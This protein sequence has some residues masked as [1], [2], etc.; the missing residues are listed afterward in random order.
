MP[1]VSQLLPADGETR[2]DGSP[3]PP[4]PVAPRRPAPARLPGR[5]TAA[6]AITRKVLEFP[7]NSSTLRMISKV[8]TGEPAAPCRPDPGGGPG[9]GDVGE[10]GAGGGRGGLVGRP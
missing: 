1:P 5:S 10:P 3:R 8:D 4:V 9:A 2:S 6:S 7:G